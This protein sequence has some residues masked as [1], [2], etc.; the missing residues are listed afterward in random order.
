MSERPFLERL[1]PSDREALLALGRERGLPRDQVLFFEGEPGHDVHLLLEGQV[2]AS[3]VS[4]SGREVILDVIDAGWLLGELSAIDGGPRSATVTAMVPSTVRVI[5][6]AEFVAYLESHPRVS[7]EV[8]RMVALRLR[9]ASQR[10]LEFG[11]SDALGR[12]C[13][14]VMEMAERYGTESDGSVRV[15]LPL[16]QTEIAAMTGLSREA[17]VKGLRALRSLEW[18][19]SDGREVTLL[20]RDAVVDRGAR[21]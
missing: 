8:V 5:T 16:S 18:I 19:E 4:R 2:K 10:Q 20:D 21:E 12:L 14:C 3:M 7:T 11:A 13:A 6:I 9:Q 1:S 17:V 15:T